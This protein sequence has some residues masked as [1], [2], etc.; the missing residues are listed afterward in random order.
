MCKL[1]KLCGK[2]VSKLPGVSIIDENTIKCCSAD[3]RKTNNNS[4]LEF[5][6][7]MVAMADENNKID[8]STI[9]YL[10]EQKDI[11]IHELRDKVTI[12][13]EQ[14]VLLKDVLN[15]SN[16]TPTNALNKNDS[17]E[18]VSDLMI[19]ENKNIADAKFTSSEVLSNP[20]VQTSANSVEFPIMPT[21][22]N[23]R[24]IKESWTEVVK[25]NSNKRSYTSKTKIIVGG[26]SSRLTKVSI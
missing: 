20:R 21:T 13:M 2:I 3:I 23:T 5:Y 22:E 15:N 25:K 18:L 24:E 10:I 19:I 11:V 8:V 17:K 12:L 4:G 26:N 9:S 6:D 14:I 7:A 16:V 1:W